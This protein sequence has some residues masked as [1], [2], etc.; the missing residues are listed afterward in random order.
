MTLRSLLILNTALLLVPMGGAT[1]GESELAPL[2]ADRVPSTS[3]AQ[4]PP[5]PPPP[6]LMMGEMPPINTPEPPWAKDLDLSDEQLDRIQAIH[7]QAIAEIEGLRQKLLKADRQ[8]RSL[9]ESNAAPEQL[10]Q[11]HQQ[12]QAIHQQLDSK[13]FEKMLAERQV[14]TPEQRAELAK[15]M[16]QHSR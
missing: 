5:C 11:Q 13:H 15:L 1:W 4:L 16:R 14:L 12:I 9:L 2:E 8:M 3:I 10:R 6:P 7:E